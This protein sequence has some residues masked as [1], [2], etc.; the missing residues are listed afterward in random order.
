MESELSYWLERY[1]VPI[2]VSAFGDTGGLFD[3]A[4]VRKC[5]HLF[6][7]LVP[8]SRSV[9][10]H[11]RV[12]QSAELPVLDLTST[13]LRR[14]YS[15]VPFKTDVELRKS[16]M[17][18]QRTT[19]LLKAL[20]FTGFVVVPAAWLLIE[21]NAPPW[22]GW[23]VLFYGVYQLYVQALKLMGLWPKTPADLAAAD[24]ERRMRHHHY[25]CELN[26]EG[27]RRL[28]AENLERE[29]REQTRREVEELRRAAGDTRS[30]LTSGYA[31]A[32]GDVPGAP[33]LNRGG[34]ADDYIRSR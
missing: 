12:V 4:A 7:W 28:V 14:L 33:R 18:Q 22:L 8:N 29:S 19:R 24:D 26:P 32:H 5:D 16:A 3:L 15:D 1:P 25:H 27:F 11:W 13:A 34:W 10:A 17:K 9:T 30:W 6:G 23:A 21:F 31:T 2:M 20:V